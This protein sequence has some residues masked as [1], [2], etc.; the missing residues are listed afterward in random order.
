MTPRER[1]EKIQWVGKTP[2][3]LWDE[4]EQAITDAVAEARAEVE[5]RVLEEREKIAQWADR[6][7]HHSPN[8]VGRW[9]RSLEDRGHGY[10]AG[11]NAS[12]VPQ[13]D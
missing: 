8:D 9:I 3:E 10:V 1:A 4:M 13:A 12:S 6:T 11:S 7:F 5:R 2:K